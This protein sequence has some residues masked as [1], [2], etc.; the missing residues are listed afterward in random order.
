MMSI[1]PRRAH[2]PVPSP[3]TQLLM[4]GHGLTACSKAL[5]LTGSLYLATIQVKLEQLQNCAHH[6][7]HFPC[8]LLILCVLPIPINN[9]VKY[10]YLTVT[11]S[12]LAVWS[13]GSNG[14]TKQLVDQ[15]RPLLLKY[16]VD[17]YVC[18]YYVSY[19]RC[20]AWGRSGEGGRGGGIIL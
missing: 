9:G 13:V 10:H 18:T 17:G 16:G 15:L 3:I 14:P 2:R 4:S 1:Q 12:L 7:I 11:M 5:L 6:N 8:L 20:N 19:H